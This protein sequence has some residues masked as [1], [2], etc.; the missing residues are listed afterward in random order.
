MGDRW[1]RLLLCRKS[2]VKVDCLF[3]VSRDWLIMC[4]HFVSLSALTIYFVIRCT[5]QSKWL[6]VFLHVECDM[7]NRGKP[8]T[9][10]P[11]RRP[12]ISDFC[13]LFLFFSADGIK[14][15]FKYR[16][17]IERQ[18]ILLVKQCIHVWKKSVWLL[19]EWVTDFKILGNIKVN[20]N[21]PI[22]WDNLTITN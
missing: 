6:L 18:V 1:I 9:L 11:C 8:R 5:E 21:Y 14:P 4:Y 13:I 10:Y 19:A 12:S 15:L 7:D 16:Y 17:L 2:V 20:M 22:T 3:Q